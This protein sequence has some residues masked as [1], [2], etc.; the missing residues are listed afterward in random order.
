MDIMLVEKAPC[1]W[2]SNRQTAAYATKYPGS[3]HRD[4][5]TAHSEF[6]GGLVYRSSSLLQHPLLHCR[7]FDS[8]RAF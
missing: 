3:V 5:L 7:L 1:G 4:R 6:S 2:Q 8:S